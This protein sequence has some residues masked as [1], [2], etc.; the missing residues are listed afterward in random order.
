MGCVSCV[1]F[2]SLMRL[3]RLV[4]FTGL[5]GFASL[6]KPVNFVCL[7][8][9]MRFVGFMRLVSLVRFAVQAGVA[10]I[11]AIAG[12]SSGGRQQAK[13]QQRRLER[14]TE[15]KIIRVLAQKLR[16]SCD[17]LVKK[18][19]P[20]QHRH[21]V[22]QVLRALTQTG[23]NVQNTHHLVGQ[24]GIGHQRRL[25]R[26][27]RRAVRGPYSGDKTGTSTSTSTS[28]DTGTRA[29][30]TASPN[31]ST[32]APG[33][34]HHRPQW[35]GRRRKHRR[36]KALHAVVIGFS[37]PKHNVFN[38]KTPHFAAPLAQ[39]RGQRGKVGIAR[40]NRKQPNPLLKMQ[41]DRIDDQGGV[42][43][44]FFQR[45]IGKGARA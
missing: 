3:V 6:V 28:T 14:G 26:R 18:S 21:N 37:V 41:R 4:D 5:V 1:D 19:V 39:A 36:R 29:S 9:L 8:C 17:A 35:H 33:G 11:A 12:R 13:G 23:H 25:R 7:L 16:R 44:V 24:I 38:R 20:L 45:Q 43:G 40:G 31:I 34:R 10:A 42:G 30:T 22:A 2:I 27:G 32:T 15:F